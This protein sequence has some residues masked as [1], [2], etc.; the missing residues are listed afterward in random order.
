MRRQRTDEVRTLKKRKTY[1]SILLLVLLTSLLAVAQSADAATPKLR[2]KQVCELGPGG[3]GTGSVIIYGRGFTPGPVEATFSFKGGDRENG[4]FIEG[5]VAD[6]RGRF[7]VPGFTPNLPLDFIAVTAR[8][9]SNPE[10][11]AERT[12]KH[13]C[14]RLAHRITPVP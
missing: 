2:L 9:A 6:A 13:P 12:I 4:D 14:Q 3:F 11:F 5:V 7:V 8:S 1:L 10:E